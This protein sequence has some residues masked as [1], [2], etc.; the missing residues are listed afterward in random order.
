MSGIRILVAMSWLVV[1]HTGAADGLTFLSWNI[2]GAQADPA[3]I[4]ERARLTAAAVGR[5]DVLMLQ[6]VVSAD[7]VAA[8]ARGMGLE[9]Y[10]ISDFAPPTAITGAWQES[11]EVAIASRLR[12]ES[13]AEWDTTG[14]EP[15]GDGYPPQTSGAEV[16][17]V[18][19]T[20]AIELG[21]QRPTRGFLRANLEGGWSVYSVHWK[22][23]RGASCDATDI[24][25]ARRRELQA[26]GLVID[27]KEQI[28][29]G[30][31]V[32]VGGD[33][34]IQA[35]GRALRVGIDRAV[36]CQ[37][38]GSCAGVCGLEG[39][40]GYDDSIHQLMA[41][42]GAPRLLSASL[43]ATYVARASPG[44]AIDHILVAGPMAGWFKTAITP[45]LSGEL[46][47]GSDHRPVLAKASLA[48]EGG[49]GGQPAASR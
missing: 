12:L 35:P 10:A 25:N 42:G 16:Q 3:A 5:V 17:A 29:A 37:P 6:E 33:Y 43:E 19:L 13:V 18:S 49:E 32:V 48:G 38:T 27:A 45:S 20:L 9:H 23:S 41:M 28:E 47:F 14:R 31:T 1:S 34:N 7:Q 30:R 2:N 8:A 46:W 4:E 44:G 21:E 26:A 15:H 11:L 36:D 24:A 22:S 40:D 39:R